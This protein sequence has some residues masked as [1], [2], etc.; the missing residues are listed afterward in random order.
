[1]NITSNLFEAYLKC[2]TKCFLRS[3]GEAGAGNEYADW[4]RVQTELYRNDRIKD[5]KSI[6]AR[7][8][9]LITACLKEN[10]KTTDREYA[11]DFVARAAHLESHIHFV[12]RT[13]PKDPDTPAQF[14]PTRFIYTNKINRD[15]KL[16]LAF[17]ARVLSEVI[18]HEV[19]LGRIIHGDD[20][21]TLKA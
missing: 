17:D 18:G 16:L 4:E 9:G 12:E 2:P 14:V 3:R 19:S 7:D 5:L 6:A 11:F 10:S 1:M 13:P 8:G 20:H 21:A 15:D